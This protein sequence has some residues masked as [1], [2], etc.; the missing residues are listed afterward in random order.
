MKRRENIQHLDEYANVIPGRGRPSFRAGWTMEYSMVGPCCSSQALVAAN[1]RN[2]AM[3]VFELDFGRWLPALKNCRWA[4]K[5]RCHATRFALYYGH[6]FRTS[7]EV[8]NRR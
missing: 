6:C 8:N 7:G 3:L 2:W 5:A 1:H 4:G